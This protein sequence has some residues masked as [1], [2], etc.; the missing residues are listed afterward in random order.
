MQSPVD[1]SRIFRL[2]LSQ[3][4]Q[5]IRLDDDSLDYDWK[6]S[7]N[8]FHG[9]LG[10][11]HLRLK[12]RVERRDKTYGKAALVIGGLFLLLLL[13]L[14][15][16]LSHYAIVLGGVLLL[17]VVGLLIRER[18][19]GRTICVQIDP[20]PF[21]FS[22][23]LPVPNTKAGKAFLMELDAAWQA[24]LRRRFLVRDVHPMMILKRI[25]WLEHIGVL[26]SEEAAAERSTVEMDGQPEQK[27]IG[28][29]VN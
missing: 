14:P 21:G 8:D 16:S 29:A 10:Y 24:S 7:Q 28:F 15:A 2:P 22:D 18:V 23:Q 6:G 27:A 11:E 12:M 17:N 5:T 9:T 25:D 3:G 19:R 4:I 1:Q 20:K 13:L 26:T